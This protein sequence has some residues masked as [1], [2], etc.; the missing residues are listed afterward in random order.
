MLSNWLRHGLDPQAALDA[1]REWWLDLEGGCVWY[2]P[3]GDR[4]GAEPP[5]FVECE[6]IFKVME[7]KFRESPEVW[8]AHVSLLLD[9]HAA[10][11][12]DAAGSSDDDAGVD[13][14]YIN[15]ARG[16]LDRG[17]VAL[18]ARDH[19]QLVVSSAVQ[20]YAQP[21]GPRVGSAMFEKILANSPRKV[22]VWSVYIDQEA[23]L[24]RLR[25]ERRA[26]SGAKSRGKKADAEAA[27]RRGE[28]LDR[29]RLLFDRATALDLK[30]KKMKLLFKKY[31]DF[32]TKA[33]AK[34][35]DAS[36]DRVAYVKQRA[37]EF[38]S[39]KMSDPGS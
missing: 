17:L 8:L 2:A 20:F 15:A 35:N 30:A 11:N 29:V 7:R 33:A 37:M 18:P 31:L 21:G 39:R 27:R 9:R 10:L 4:D 5:L 14:K 1:P 22:D 13:M 23:K 38:V 19:L 32:E 24:C 12:A 3:D 28:D 26:A 25:V 16:V 6:R 36:G 34:S